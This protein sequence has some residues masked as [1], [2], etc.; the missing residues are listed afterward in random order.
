MAFVNQ[1][2][3]ENDKTLNKFHYEMVFCIVLAQA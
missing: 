2:I 1:F 3:R